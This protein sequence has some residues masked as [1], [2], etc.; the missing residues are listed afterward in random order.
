MTIK[1]RIAVR[2]FDGGVKKFEDRIDIS[3]EQLETLL[4]ALAEKHGGAM[5]M[6]EISMIEIEFLDEPNREAAFFRIGTDPR[7]MRHPVAIN[8][9]GRDDVN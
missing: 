2:G 4:P 5:A 9:E 3:D 8:L 6:R 1:T 7:G